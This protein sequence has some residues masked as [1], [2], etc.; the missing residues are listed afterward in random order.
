MKVIL[1]EIHNSRLSI[2]GKKN[3]K[4]EE[5]KIF[6][7][8]EIHILQKSLDGNRLK[9]LFLLNL[10]T[11]LRQREI[12]ALKWDDIDMDKKELHMKKSIKKVSVIE[13]DNIRSYKTIEQEPKSQSSIRTVPIPSS[14]IPILKKHKAQQ[15]TE[16]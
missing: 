6:T 12:L 13:N 16:N 10:G 5:I 1:I 3:S 15:G 2:P 8:G 14:L 4:K 7:D 9:A 11:G